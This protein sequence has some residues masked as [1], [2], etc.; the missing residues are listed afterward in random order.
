MKTKYPK[1]CVHCKVASDTIGSIM[2]GSPNGG[3]VLIAGTGSNSLLFYPD[4]F[5]VRCGGWGHLIGDYGSAYWI[6][7]Q[8]VRYVIEAEENYNPLP[9]EISHVKAVIYKHF[10][11]SIRD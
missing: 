8:L 7:Q 11:V 3:I 1:L 9:F 6:S 4:G 5:T 10:N 2:T